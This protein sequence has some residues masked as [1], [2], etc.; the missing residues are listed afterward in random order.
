MQ[1]RLLGMRSACAG[2]VPRLDDRQFHDK[3]RAFP[4]TRAFRV[5]FACKGFCQRARNRKPEPKTTILPRYIGHSLRKRTENILDRFFVHTDS[6]VANL[7]DY[8]PVFI[9][10]ADG[11]HAKLR[12]EFDSISE[13]VPDDL[14]EAGRI[15]E[16][17]MARSVELDMQIEMSFLDIR[18]KGYRS[19]R[20]FS[21][22]R[23]NV[24]SLIAS[25]PRAIR[26]T[27]RRCDGAEVPAPDSGESSW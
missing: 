5:E 6:R 13:Q 14:L 3:S 22:W 10:R 24:S 27:S 11:N 20:S 16:D 8:L 7:N 25:L 2:D 4:K 19:F 23:S 1:M 9:H 17:M 21:G 12:C 18:A 26:V 15:G